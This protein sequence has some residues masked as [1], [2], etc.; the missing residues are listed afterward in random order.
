[1]RKIKNLKGDITKT[2]KDR[3]SMDKLK[4]VY[5]KYGAPQKTGIITTILKSIK[6]FLITFI[7]PFWFSSNRKSLVAPY[8]YVFFDMI[9]FYVSVYVFLDLCYIAAINGIKDAGIVL[10]ALAGVITTLIAINQIM[11]SAYNK[12]KDKS[13]QVEN[14]NDKPK[15]VQ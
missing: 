14:E 8:V 11:M 4:A 7:R 15:G 1:M 6:W 3:E 2:L 13:E 10:G 9:F 12:G 5:K